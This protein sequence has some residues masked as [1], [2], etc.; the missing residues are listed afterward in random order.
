MNKSERILHD[1]EA[2]YAN[3]FIKNLDED[4]TEELIELKFSEY[5]KIVNVK[6]AKDEAGNSKGFGFVNFDNP[7]SARMAIEAMNGLQLGMLFHFFTYLP[8]VKIMFLELSY[9]IKM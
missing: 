3:L 1:R 6:I 8:R 4:I 7:E 2:N 9:V 5:G